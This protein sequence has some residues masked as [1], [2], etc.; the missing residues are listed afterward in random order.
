MRE[1]QPNRPAGDHASDL[2][3]QSAA[4]VHA[5]ERRWRVFRQRVEEIVAGGE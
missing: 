5:N 4:L 3:A 2:G 1:S